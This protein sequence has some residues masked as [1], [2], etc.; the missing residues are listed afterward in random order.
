MLYEE[1][2]RQAY[3]WPEIYTERLHH[4]F[5]SHSSNVLPTSTQLVLALWMINLAGRTRSV[6]YSTDR[7]NVVSKRYLYA[8]INN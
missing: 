1:T 5:Y 6:T 3:I 8:E 4:Y 7:E 2:E